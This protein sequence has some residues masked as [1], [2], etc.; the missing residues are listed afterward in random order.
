ML[1]MNHE[2][3][4]VPV[5]LWLDKDVYLIFQSKLY[6]PGYSDCHQTSKVQGADQGY[7]KTAM[8][9]ACKKIGIF[10]F[11]KKSSIFHLKTIFFGKM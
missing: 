10:H 8:L 3:G 9:L 1:L 6:G 4:F 7:G 11:Y 2:H 5:C